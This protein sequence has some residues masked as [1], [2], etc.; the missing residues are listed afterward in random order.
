[1][2]LICMVAIVT[3]SLF[4]SHTILLSLMRKFCNCLFLILY[5]LYSSV[6]SSPAPNKI[7]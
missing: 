5:L 2:D 3:P 7:K 1:M 6:L 4:C